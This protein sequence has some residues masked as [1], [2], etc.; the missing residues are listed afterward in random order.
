MTESPGTARTQEASGEAG[1]PVRTGGRHHIEVLLGLALGQLGGVIPRNRTQE[2]LQARMV[3]ALRGIEGLPADP[4]AEL[5]VLTNGAHRQALLEFFVAIGCMV[6]IDDDA[7]D[8]SGVQAC[9]NA[10]RRFGETQQWAFAK[11]SLWFFERF[12]GTD[13]LLGWLPERE[14]E[15]WFF[16]K[17]G[18]HSESQ[19]VCVNILSNDVSGVDVEDTLDRLGREQLRG[20]HVCFFKSELYQRSRPFGGPSYLGPYETAYWRTS[21][22]NR[23]LVAPHA[24]WKLKEFLLLHGV[25]PTNDPEALSLLPEDRG[26]WRGYDR[27]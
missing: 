27:D 16:H 22:G 17:A 14:V 8:I 13:T 6:L 21:A 12:L 4:A 24:Q 26:G 18:R 7:V 3:A 19:R 10:P 15:M 23:L 25:R 9:F 1:G 20:A 11:A 2:R 5:R